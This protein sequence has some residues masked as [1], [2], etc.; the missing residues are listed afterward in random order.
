MI[1][2]SSE[3]DLDGFYALMDDLRERVGG[4]RY[5]RSCTS[6]SGWPKRGVYFFFDDDEPR[7]G[8]KGPR[9]VRVGTHA[10]RYGER[11]TLWGR[12]R[13]HRGRNDGKHPG[14][15]DH[16]GSVFRKHVGAAMI[17]RDV[18]LAEVGRTWFLNDVPREE[19]GAEMTLE[20]KVSSY[21]GSLPFLWVDV[22][23]EPGPMSE[24]GLIERSAI[25][26]L[27][28]GRDPRDPPT[29]DWLGLHAP[30]SAMRQSGLWN[31][32]HVDDPIETSFLDV[33]SN[34]VRGTARSRS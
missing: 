30:D 13:G 28:N 16:R 17:D 3:A 15:G 34:R 26:L 33:L 12:L 9:V 18:K 10:L 25:A 23:D 19:R 22:D 21:V 27:S 4:Y 6:R 2:L 29:P 8:G 24:R 11:S 20:V 5:L 31:V 32:R 1:R 7:S 14:S